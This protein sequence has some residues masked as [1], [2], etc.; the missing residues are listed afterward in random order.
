MESLPAG[1]AQ[2]SGLVA[3]LSQ[4]CTTF[5]AGSAVIAVALDGLAD[6][7]RAR[8][9]VEIL[10]INALVLPA[11]V[12]ELAVISSRRCAVPALTPWIGRHPSGHRKLSKRS[13]ISQYLRLLTTL[14]NT[15]CDQLVTT[16]T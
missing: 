14:L 13:S 5:V 9:L 12:F 8:E 11:A 7:A 3:F 6:D 16:N 2:Q 4:A 1:I 15:A 10:A